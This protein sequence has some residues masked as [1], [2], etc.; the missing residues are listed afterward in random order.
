[1]FLFCRV[2]L[3][4]QLWGLASLGGV[5]VALHTALHTRVLPT[6]L[7]NCERFSS[8]FQTNEKEN[9][10]T[11]H[12]AGVKWARHSGRY[13]Q[14]VRRRD[15]RQTTIKRVDGVCYGRVTPVLLFSDTPLV[16]LDDQSHWHQYNGVSESLALPLE[17][18][19]QSCDELSPVPPVASVVA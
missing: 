17:V 2:A 13:H 12:T 6:A 15:L 3:W 19:T 9:L 7:P 5:D 8:R 16:H 11:P 4:L 1:M 18:L 10:G 14:T